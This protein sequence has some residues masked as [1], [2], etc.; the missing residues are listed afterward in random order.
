M[1]TAGQRCTSLRR[2]IVHETIY[3]ALVARLKQVYLSVVVGD[4]RAEGTL[5]GPLIDKRSFAGM[6]AALDEARS[7]G[8]MI[9][10]GDRLQSREPK[11]LFM[12]GLR[13]WRSRNNP[14]W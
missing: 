5:V 9:T 4:P 2:L 6:R 1:G 14:M 13:W 8:A 11:R 7:G 12:F 10:G 3:D